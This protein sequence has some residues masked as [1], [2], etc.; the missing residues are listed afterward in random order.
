MIYLIRQIN[1]INRI[2]TFYMIFSFQ[3]FVIKKKKKKLEMN[4]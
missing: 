4:N 2:I 1:I 3:V